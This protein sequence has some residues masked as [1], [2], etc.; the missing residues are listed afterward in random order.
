MLK[1]FI[2]Y[3][4][5]QYIKIIFK[6]LLYNAPYLTHPKQKHNTQ[7]M[8]KKLEKKKREKRNR[9]LFLHHGSILAPQI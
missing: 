8:I 1:H 9:D 7:Q 6:N 4:T 2:L 5:I 3:F